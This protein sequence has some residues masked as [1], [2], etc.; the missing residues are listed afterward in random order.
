MTTIPRELAEHFANGELSSMEGIT[1]DFTYD[2]S[3]YLKCLRDNISTGYEAPAIEYAENYR[4]VMLALGKGSDLPE[5]RAYVRKL[6]A[7]AVRVTLYFPCERGE[8]IEACASRAHM[9]V[10]EF[11]RFAIC[12]YVKETVE[13]SGIV[14]QLGRRKDGGA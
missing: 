2:T 10:Q 4:A 9:S 6:K 1:G 7:E 8:E 12:R 5:P 3:G 14:I 13:A 11:A